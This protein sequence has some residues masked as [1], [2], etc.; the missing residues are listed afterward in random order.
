MAKGIVTFNG[1]VSIR[2]IVTYIPFIHETNLR[3]WF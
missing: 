1:S 2:V 3:A